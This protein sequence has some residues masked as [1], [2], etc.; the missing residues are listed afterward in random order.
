MKFVAFSLQKRI[1]ITYSRR[2]LSWV[3]LFHSNLANYLEEICGAGKFS[4]FRDDESVR[5]GHNWVTAI[6]QNL[7]QVD[8][9][10]FIATPEAIAST[11]VREELDAVISSFSDWQ[12]RLI[13]IHLL[14][15]P[16]PTFLRAIQWSEEFLD[17]DDEAYLEGLRALAGVL[18][19]ENPGKLPLFTGE[20][21][22]RAPRSGLPKGFRPRL[23]KWLALRMREPLFRLGII[24]ALQLKIGD[25]ESGNNSGAGAGGIWEEPK[26]HPSY[27]CAAST[28]L[29]RATGDQHAFTAVRRILEGL[30]QYFGGI[31]EA[32]PTEL[33]ELWKILDKSRRELSSLPEKE[34]LELE[35][36]EQVDD[37][38]RDLYL[39]G[40]QETLPLESICVDPLV[41]EPN[42]SLIHDPKRSDITLQELLLDQSAPKQWILLGDPGS[43]KTIALQNL[44]WRLAHEKGHYL[45]V[46]ESLPRLIETSEDL[47]ENVEQRLKSTRF[48]GIAQHLERAGIDG[49]L[50]L[51]FDGLD[52]ISRSDRDEANRRLRQY[53]R[54]WPKSWM[55]VASRPIGHQPPG[56]E[57]KELELQPLGPN[58]RLKILHN[59]FNRR[60]EQDKSIQ[61][62]TALQEISSDRGLWELSRNPLYLY[63]IAMLFEQQV[64]PKNNRVALYDQVIKFLLGSLDARQVLG[65]ELPEEICELLAFIAYRLT[66]EDLDSESYGQLQS[67]LYE[68]EIRKLREKLGQHEPWKEGVRPILEDIRKTGLFGPYEGPKA[69]WRFFHRSIRDALTSRYL[70]NKN[71]QWILEH[72]EQIGKDKHENRWAEPFALLTGRV[73]DPNKLVLKLAAVNPALARRA[74]ATARNLK[75]RT[76]EK[77]FGLEGS[78]LE[79]ST[80]LLRIPELLE[81]PERVLTLLERILDSGRFRGGND[82]FFINQTLDGLQLYASP[83]L[84]EETEEL[85]QKLFAHVQPTSALRF[86]KGSRE[87]E[88]D[89]KPYWADIPRGTFRMGSC[90]DSAQKDEGPQHSVQILEPFRI[91]RSPVTVDLF[92]ALDPDLLN[93]PLRFRRP[94][95]LSRQPAVNISWYAASVFCQWLST[96]DPFFYGARL[97]TEEEWEYTCRAG[98]ETAYWS[99]DSEADLARVGWYDANSEDRVQPVASKAPNPWG[100]YD[101]HGNVMEWTASL[102]DRTA[103]ETRQKGYEHDPMTVGEE[104]LTNPMQREAERVVRGGGYWDSAGSARSA[105]RNARRPD[106]EAPNLGFRIVIPGLWKP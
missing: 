50:V 92:Q 5:P 20:E 94:M 21:I 53:A 67:L 97:P 40:Q 66:A 89:R 58:Q 63:L 68:Q 72:A 12:S 104:A 28:T 86:F 73:K 100:L 60:E 33:Q 56:F 51:L 61:A 75:L 26:H 99:G 34:R 80:V 35:Y 85:R 6:Q 23:V 18:L 69:D 57:F 2:D 9:L 102:Y 11:R 91:L 37:D 19:H 45:P 77:I 88:L 87:G 84:L 106:T 31:S 81:E 32:D 16:R 105:S 10:L 4:I 47:L 76:L 93:V 52:E 64:S 13:P 42:S 27:E 25:L 24:Q 54:Q 43:G 30:I 95:D 70:V 1:F 3:A 74:V 101:M 7:D 49:R 8:H 46:S 83:E 14:E 38:L 29:V 71:T 65:I 48:K 22:P 39:L 62:E 17:H 90:S 82:L 44:A 78:W 15:S 98:T 59:L 96:L 103:Y 36:L 79:R 41:R 55:I